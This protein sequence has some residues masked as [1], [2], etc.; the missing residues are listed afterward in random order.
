[1]AVYTYYAF[2]LT[3]GDIITEVPLRGA[4]PTWQVNDPGSL[5]SPTISLG[6]LSNIQRADI[7]A[8]T[9]PWKTGIAVDRDGTI[10]WSG[11]VTGR[12]YDSGTKKFSITV[13]GLL[14]YWKRRIL[15]QNIT[16]TNVDQFD[17]VAGLLRFGGPPTVP[18][19]M[20]YDPSGMKRDRSIAGSDQKNALDEILEI[21]DN[22][23]GFELAID[24][25]W[26]QTPGIQG[27]V[28]SLRIGSPRLGN[29]DSHTGAVL[30]LEYPGNATSFVWD[31]DGEEF[32]TQV[33]GSSTDQDGVVTT[34]SAQN[35]VLLAQGFP[36]VGSTRQWSNI[37]NS[38]T[39][40]GHVTQAIVESNGYQDAPTFAVKDAGDTAAGSWV[41]GDDVRVRIT[42]DARFPR[43][44][45]YLGPGLD[46]TVRISQATL[47]PVTGTIQ[48][49]M[50]GFLEAVQ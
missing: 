7:R 18:M 14:A 15:D 35:P 19:V 4:G 42:D 37:T 26:D 23:N 29:V 13:P 2:T 1:M 8:A 5:G 40:I 16:Y 3:T 48:M 49:T 22:Q 27:V 36:Q 41:V 46:Q 38:D 17:I 45:D 6:A 9:V 30:T 44:Q 24:T 47:D 50:F 10:I 11:V 20:Q 21:A 39:L 31:E 12:R 25:A 28:H 33:Y 32:A 43:I 34:I